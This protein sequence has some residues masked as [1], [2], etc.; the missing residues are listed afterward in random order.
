MDGDGQTTGIVPGTYSVTIRV[1]ETNY[2]LTLDLV[3][4]DYAGAV[5]VED[6]D[7]LQFGRW[8][9]MFLVLVCDHDGYLVWGAD[10]TIT[11][12]YPDGTSEERADSTI[13]SA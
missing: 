9:F 4:P 11:W 12:Y 5:H 10:I 7:T 13:W 1:V 2:K 8:N 6:I 3:I